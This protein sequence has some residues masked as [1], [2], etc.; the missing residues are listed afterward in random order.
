MDVSVIIVSYNTRQLTLDC[1]ESVYKKTK[2]IQFEIFVVDNASKDGS[3]EAIKNNFPNVILIENKEN[4]GFGFAN[5]LAIIKSNAKYVFL[6]NSDCVLLDNSILSFFTFMENTEHKSIACVGGTLLDSNNNS[7][8]SYGYFPSLF[9][10]TMGS[11]FHDYIK[12][13]SIFSKKFTKNSPRLVDYITGAD[14]FIKKDILNILGLFDEKFFL[15][16]EEAD[17]QYRFRKAG[18]CSV[19]LSEVKIYHLK[20][21]SSNHKSKTLNIISSRLKYINKHSSAFNLL[22]FKIITILSLLLKILFTL[23]KRLYL[24]VLFETVKLFCKKGVSF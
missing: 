4:K 9:R 11:T 20:G 6:L 21:A 3:V 8:H 15:Y 22:I 12:N 2:D 10:F 16:Y 24:R 18:L 17:L 19:I 7:I 14:L 1:I 5:N 23:K 13:K